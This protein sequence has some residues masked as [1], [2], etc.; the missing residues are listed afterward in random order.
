MSTRGSD[1]LPQASTP[2]RGSITPRL[3]LPAWLTPLLVLLGMAGMFAGALVAQRL[4]LGLRGVLVASES[5][6]VLPSVFAI[7]LAGIPLSRGLGLQGVNT[8]DALL[9]L[10]LGASLWM[11]S[12]G[13]MSL[14]SLIWPPN[15]AFLESFK[16]LHRA[17]RPQGPFD[18]VL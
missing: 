7:L 17:L 10:L 6:L 2:S 18:A 4:G 14:Q 9:S 3:A 8:R 11:V 12:L 5:G 13:L 15:E 1:P 16:N